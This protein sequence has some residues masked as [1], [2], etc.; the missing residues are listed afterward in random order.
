MSTEQ[1]QTSSTE[2]AAPSAAPQTE[3][4]PTR[5]FLTSSLDPLVMGRL[6]KCLCQSSI[7]PQLFRQ[8][9]GAVMYVLDMAQRLNCN[10]FM[11]M[12]NIYN[13]Q[14]NICMSGKFCCSL[15]QQHPSYSRI[16]Y[17]Y[18]NP[19]N[20]EEGVRVVGVRKDGETDEGPWVTLRLVKGEGWLDKRGS[21]WLTMPDLMAR[22]RAA[23]FFCRVFCPD[24]LMG[25]QTAEEVM[26]FAVKPT[27][28]APQRRVFRQYKEQSEDAQPII[29]AESPESTEEPP[30]PEAQPEPQLFAMDETPEP[31][32]AYHD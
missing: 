9:Q 2:L 29:E 23:A 12:Q 25:M 11:L 21:K 6:A 28:Q 18:A 17:E 24:A 7:V 27:T 19:Q 14:G 13:V 22:Y 1:Q 30:A 20:W 10:V 26:D 5:G 16:R 15:L 4:L 3:L 8:D 32:T 31:A